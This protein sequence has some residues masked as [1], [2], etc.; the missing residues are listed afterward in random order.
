MQI[1]NKTE[2]QT[3]STFLLENIEDVCTHKYKLR[4]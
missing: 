2:F 4:I 1:A 3:I